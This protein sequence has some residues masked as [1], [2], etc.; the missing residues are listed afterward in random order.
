[1]SEFV[2]GMSVMFILVSLFLLSDKKECEKL[3]NVYECKRVY[4]PVTGESE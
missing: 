2:G 3:H 4:I 1:M